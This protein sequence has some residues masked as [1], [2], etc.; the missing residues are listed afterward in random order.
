MIKKSGH[1]YI[2]QFVIQ[3]LSLPVLIYIMV[4]ANISSNFFH[5]SGEQK[6][7]QVI[8]R[9]SISCGPCL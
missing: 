4:F 9:C 7:E 1:G 2:M 6:I 5:P 8:K 3:N